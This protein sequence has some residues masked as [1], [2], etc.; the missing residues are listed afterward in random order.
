MPCEDSNTPGE[1]CDDRD[2]DWS[3]A[4]VSQGVARI[5]GHDQKLERGKEGF[6]AEVHG[7]AD[8]LIWDS[9]PQNYGRTNFCFFKLW[10]LKDNTICERRSEEAWLGKQREK[11]SSY[12]RPTNPRPAWW[13]ASPSFSQSMWAAPWWP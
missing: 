3:N 12:I 5:S 9:L 13:G 7:P 1:L 2:R 4:T 11:A 8:T 6:C 10:R